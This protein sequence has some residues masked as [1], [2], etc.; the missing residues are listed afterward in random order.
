MIYRPGHPAG[1][2]QPLA[3]RP[4]RIVSTVPSQTEL[5]VD[6]GLGDALVGITAYCVRPKGLLKQKTI[7]GGTKDLQ[8]DK[9][10]SLAPD[11][12]LG[13]HEE[14]VKEQIET[15]KN[16]FPVWISDVRSVSDALQMIRQLGIL[17]HTR[18]RAENIFQNIRNERDTLQ[19]TQG[20]KVAYFIWKDPYML[21]GPDTFIGQMLE[22]CG[23]QNV[24][25]T[26]KGRYPQL[27]L[28]ELE[29]L[30]PDLILLSSEPYPFT[31]ADAH[32]IAGQILHPLVKIVDGELFSWY[33]SRMKPAFRY[34]SH[35]CKDLFLSFYENI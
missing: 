8:I 4:Q 19:K 11:L 16:E 26:G 28:G 23:L 1:T 9:I 5:L 2:V 22:E 34:F 30:E 21:A 35:F 32:F 18:E 12:I 7:I 27:S 20:L 13:N 31:T 10:R 15:L 29:A 14:N 6:L 24:A 3:T 33:G 17:T 25:P